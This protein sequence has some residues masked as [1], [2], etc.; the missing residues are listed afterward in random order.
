MQMSNKVSTVL[1]IILILIIAAGS[2]LLISSKDKPTPSQPPPLPKID[3]ELKILSLEGTKIKQEL[4]KTD[5]TAGDLVL[6]DNLDFKINYL[7]VPH[8]Q[9]IVTIKS[10]PFETSRAEAE[11]W[12]T[13]KG[14]T[15]ADLCL[16]KITFAVS[17]ET[18]PDFTAADAI[19]SG[20]PR[21]AL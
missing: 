10:K 15:A 12:F 21:P 13:D 6:E 4:V 20:C 2:W 9:F 11:K 5:K 14:F 17:K 18:K 7:P 3:Q 16:L 19:P 8:D 1:K